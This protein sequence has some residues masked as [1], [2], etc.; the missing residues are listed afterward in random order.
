MAIQCNVTASDNVYIGSDKSL[1]IPIYQSDGKTRQDITG[2]ALSW[3][4]KASIHDADASAVITK[5]TV[6]G[7]T[8]SSPTT[9][10]CV[11]TL[12]AADTLSLDPA[13]YVHELKRTTPGSEDVV[14]DGT[15]VLKR[16]V[17]RS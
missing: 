13:T 8:L 11:V 17:H 1:T 7:I 16:G 5:T 9:G 2:W 10:V 6:N 12:S 15:F 3:M 14:T 4:L